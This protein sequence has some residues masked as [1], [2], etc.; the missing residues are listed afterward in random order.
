MTD[1]RITLSELQL[2]IRDTL[3]FAFPE[4]VWV[5]AEISEIKVNSAG[6][7]YLELIEK[8]PEE[9]NVKARIKAIIWSK[10]FRF[11]R[12][13]FENVSGN[14][15][16]EGLKILVRATVEYHE[17]Y[18]LSLIITDIDPAFTVGEMAIRRHEIINRLQQEGIFTLNKEIK[19]PQ[20]PQ[21]IAVI[22]SKNAAGY[23]DFINHLKDN[24]EGYVFYTHLFETTLQGAEAEVSI[25]NSLD[26]IAFNSHLF[27]V[28][29][30]IRGGGSQSDLSW[31]DNYNIAYHITQ[32]PLAVITG[33]GHDKDVSITD[34]VANKSLRTPTAVA[35]FLID[36]LKEAENHILTMCPEI[37]KASSS[38]ID[39]YKS[40]LESSATRLV[41][42]VRLMMSQI[43]AR[44]SEHIL[45]TI[46]IGKEL[47]LRAGL[48]PAN[49]GTRITSSAENLI[50]GRKRALTQDAQRLFASTTTVI[51]LDKTRI[52]G[53]EDSLS[54]LNPS[55]IL[56]RGYSITTLNGKILKSADSVKIDDIITTQLSEGIIKSKIL[57]KNGNSE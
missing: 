6:H 21:R 33:I 42:L 39:N 55:N 13:Y 3:Y 5:I 15:L 37:I 51:R 2:I 45:N 27:D 23:T 20:V 53:L 19:L 40:R 4:T 22:S 35:T 9:K 26:R 18:G 49:L 17:L 43:K 11:L 54:H 52:K 14:N 44:L 1:K 57:D 12:A 28:V 47:I 10:Q 36:T 46:N 16:R 31:F 41:P 25:I 48:I 56:K 7:C 38:I 24:S 34:M 8:N 29:A 32:F 30:I 50:S